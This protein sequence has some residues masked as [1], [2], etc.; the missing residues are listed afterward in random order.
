MLATLCLAEGRY[1]PLRRWGATRYLCAT[2][3]D[4]GDQSSSGSGCEMLELGCVWCC[5]R[6]LYGS[7]PGCSVRECAGMRPRNP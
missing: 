5:M 6:V 1:V 4:R 2:T 7:P 3:D